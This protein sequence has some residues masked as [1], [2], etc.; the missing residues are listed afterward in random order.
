MPDPILI[1]TAMSVALGVSGALSAI[2]GWP[3][4]ALGPRCMTWGGFWA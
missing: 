3:W 1:V 4:P 2:I